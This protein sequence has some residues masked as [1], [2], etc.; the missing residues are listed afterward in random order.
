MT[1]GE[2]GRLDGAHVI[3]RKYAAAMRSTS[4]RSAAVRSLPSPPHRAAN[5]QS[6]LSHTDFRM[7]RL[8]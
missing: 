1:D 6:S 3:P 5:E 2:L 7:Y 4:A 8:D